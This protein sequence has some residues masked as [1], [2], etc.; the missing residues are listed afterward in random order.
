MFVV[1]GTIIIGF[2][3]TVY[4]IVFTT[5]WWLAVLY[6]FWIYVIDKD[7]SERGGRPIKW[8]QSWQLWKY[9]RD[10]FPLRFEKLPGVELDPKRN[11]L[12]CIYPHG[13][14]CAGAFNAFATEWG[15]FKH[16][17][18]HHVPHGVT[19][20]PHYVMPVFR[21]LALSL[22]G[23]SASAKS[24]DYVLGLPGG[25]HVCALIAG[26]VAETLYSKPGRYTIFLKK[27]RGFVRL[28]LKNGTSLVPVVSFGE[29]DLFEE[30]QGSWVTYLQE[31]SRKWFGVTLPLY[32]GRGFFQYSF[33]MMPHRRKVTTVVG[34]P[35]EIPKVED[36]TREQVDHYHAEF[37]K[38]LTDMF[39][40]QKYNYL[41]KPEEKHL[42]I[43]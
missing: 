8:L 7:V 43:V 28:A 32:T 26:G 16:Y 15:G 35:I 13:A 20:S 19:M 42:E 10:Y 5:F 37:V 31:L 40:E 22:G 17:F 36:P 3:I 33:G 29:V 18:P 30:L 2:L 39:E 25:G 21:E 4:L 9:T 41:E 1:L 14:M 34:F 23:I 27:R 11:Y 24:I 38:K 12:F 6:L